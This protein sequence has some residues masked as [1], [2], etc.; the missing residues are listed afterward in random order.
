[1]PAWSIRRNRRLGETAARRQSRPIVP[2]QA[3]VSAQ[4]DD[5]L[6]NKG[7]WSPNGELAK[8]VASQLTAKGPA[9]VVSGEIRTLPKT[10]PQEDGGIRPAAWQRVMDWYTDEAATD[11][12]RA[13]AATPS[14][15]VLEAGIGVYTIGVGTFLCQTHLKLIDPASG[16]VLGRSRG[17]DY[18]DRIRAEN[19]WANDGARFKALFS[20]IT[21]KAVTEALRDLGI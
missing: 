2:Q 12:Y 8:E 16:R 7:V 6:R 4:I 17:Y 19:L 20:Q 9:P 15:A 5:L 18:Y 11:R 1:M 13:L 10:Q 21:N 3:A 14:L